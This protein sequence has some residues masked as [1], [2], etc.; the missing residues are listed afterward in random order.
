[1]VM[2]NEFKYLI[3]LFSFLIANYNQSESNAKEGLNKF[4]EKP[5]RKNSLDTSKYLNEKFRLDTL[6]NQLYKKNVFNAN[7]LI[8]KGNDIIYK[9]SFG[10]AN[11]EKE[12]A[13]SDSSIFQLAS[14][15]KVITSIGILMLY[16]QGKLNLDAQ[17]SDILPEFPYKKMTIEHLLCHRSGLPNYTYFCCKYLKDDATDLSNRDVLELMAKYKPTPYLNQGKRFNYS[18]TNYIILAL[19]I[20]KISGLSYDTYLHK[21]LFEPLGMRH[22][23]TIK[24]LDLSNMNLT[25]GYSIK[26]KQIDNDRFDGVIGDKGIFTTTHDLILLS[27]ALYQNKLLSA[28]TQALAYTPHSKEKKMSNYGLG[29]RMKNISNENKE[30]YHNGWWHGYK[31]SFHRRLKDSLTIIILS[32]KL[33]NSVYATH[34]IYEAIDGINHSD[35]SSEIEMKA[36]Y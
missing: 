9:K 20:E 5:I 32:N 7:V 3:V 14:V 28:K 10:I 6:F 2:K 12:V 25:C 19:I 31:T 35:K 30:V 29:W 22:T 24:K 36:E 8:A 11:K 15:S 23:Q 16:E 1:M 18:N 27:T 26:F 21:K 34:K 33:N 13:L 17:V 4:F